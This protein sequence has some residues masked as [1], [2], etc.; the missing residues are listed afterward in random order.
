M[1]RRK[2]YQSIAAAG[3]FFVVGAATDATLAQG[4]VIIT[5]HIDVSVDR[6][7]NFFHTE[8]NEAAVTGLN[9]SPG[10]QVVYKTAKTRVVAD[11]TL[12]RHDYSGDDPPYGS[13]S[14]S[15]YSYTGGSARLDVTSQV[16]ERL[17]VGLKDALHVT[18]DAGYLDQYNNDNGR[19]GK[20]TTN[21]I[22]PS[23]SYDFGNKFAVGARYQHNLIDYAGNDGEDYSENRGAI[24]VFYN[25]NRTTAAFLE[26]QIWAGD[27]GGLSSDYMAN[28]VTLNIQKHFN[29]FTFTAGAGYNWRE[30]DE[31]GYKNLGGVTWKLLVDGKDRSGEDEDEDIA[32][33]SFVHLGLTHD[34]NNYGTGDSYFQATQLDL[35]GGYMF[36][37]RLSVSGQALYQYS[38]Y[39]MNPNDRTDNL[40][41]LS[42]QVEYAVINNLKVGFEGGYRNRDSDAAGQSYDDTYVMAKVSYLYNFGR[43]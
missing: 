40:Y 5:P 2:I 23:I 12:E 10:I 33:R 36:G 38:N 22:V 13:N 9:I 16:S 42:A 29:Y 14:I 37:P 3:A 43:E 19:Q 17:K 8:N 28:Q 25:F 26:Y 32:P 24:D 30:F 4:R 18:R 11:G 34:M 15:D 21:S 7:S 20:Y 41:A 35:K 31:S 27:Y 39:Q 1:E 6:T